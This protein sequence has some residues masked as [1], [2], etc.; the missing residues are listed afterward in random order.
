MARVYPIAF[1][2]GVILLDGCRSNEDSELRF[3]TRKID[4]WL[5]G[6]HDGTRPLT[7]ERY[8]R[9]SELLG[10]AVQTNSASTSSLR[11][12]LFGAMFGYLMFSRESWRFRLGVLGLVF[13]A[14]FVQLCFY[15]IY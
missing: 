1:L 8:E 2:L 7:I 6:I 10:Y 9:V 13:V 14:S 11:W 4:W 12:V 5:A 3:A 15:P